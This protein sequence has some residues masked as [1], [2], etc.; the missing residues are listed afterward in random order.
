MIHTRIARRDHPGARRIGEE[1]PYLGARRPCADGGPYSQ[2]MPSEEIP[3]A[4]IGYGVAGEVFHAPLISTTSG[5][6]L[7]TVVT[8]DP[9]RA[10]RAA[11]RYDVP[12]LARAEE[13]WSRG[14]VGLVVVAA[15]N[16]AHV[17]LARQA[18]DAGVPVVL[19]KPLAATAQAARDVVQAAAAAGVML[20][21]FQN[22]RWDG[23]LLT[24]R[25]LLAE[26]RLA[27]VTR[28]ES[29]FERWRPAP[30]PGWR[31]SG[32][33]ED[34]GGLLLDLGSHLVDQALL[35]FGPVATV[36]AE[37]DRRRPGVAVEDDVLISLRHRSGVRSQLWMSAVA[38]LGGP[39]FRVLG[40]SGGYVKYGL[41]GQEEALRAGRGP[42]EPDWGAEPPS[43]WGRFGTDAESAVVPTERGDYPA[44]YAGM[45]AALRDGVPPPV[46]PA[47][48][49]VGLEILDAARRSAAEVRVVALDN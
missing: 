25:R 2:S 5:L 33:P 1:F 6:R 49:L 43:A 20:S 12:V 17:P 39:R 4:L 8:G 47:D 40:A 24:V 35:L 10:G 14:G 41:D 44:F 22:R 15:P 18:L 38:A 26:G 36:Y 30:K 7:A 37:L 31:E 46:D 21:V 45:V 32:G 42:T 19:D 3:V 23:D 27:G 34:G 28:F 11:T 29:R 9:H 13:L 16:A 48:A